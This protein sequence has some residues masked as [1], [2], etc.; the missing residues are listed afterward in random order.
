MKRPKVF[1]CYRCGELRNGKPTL[2]ITLFPGGPR[3]LCGDCYAE[4]QGHVYV[5]TQEEP[6]G[7]VVTHALDCDLGE[8]CTCSVEALA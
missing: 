3:G 6:S 5:E 8:D 1:R 4:T 7:G 2:E